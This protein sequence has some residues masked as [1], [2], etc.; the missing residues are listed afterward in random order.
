MGRDEFEIRTGFTTEN[1]GFTLEY[2]YAVPSVLE[3]FWCQGRDEFARPEVLV[4]WV[5]LEGPVYDRWPPESHVRLS[6]HGEDARALL[7]DFMPRA[8]RRPVGDDEIDAKVALFESARAEK[9]AFIEA[10]K[11]PLVAVLTSPNFLYLPEFGERL[12][13]Y[14][15]ASRLSYFLWSSMP[16]ERLFRLAGAGGLRAAALGEEVDRLLA[17]AK[18]DAFVTNFAGQWLDLRKIGA[19]PPVTN[20]YPRYDRHLET[21]MAAESL[22]FFREML[23]GDLSVMN[24]IRSDFVTF[25]ERMARFYGIAACAGTISGGS[26]WR[27]TT[28][29]AGSSRRPRC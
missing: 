21:S 1:A 26:R 17:D 25:N 18:A 8:W 10:I 13:D 22:A 12:D 9:G 7:A 20:L 27:R 11:M 5:E 2:A 15:L 6:E 14:Q 16:D 3:N 23:K 28:T 29:A 24:F 4:D 19:N